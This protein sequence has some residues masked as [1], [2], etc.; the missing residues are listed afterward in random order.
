MVAGGGVPGGRA[1]RGLRT[2]VGNASVAL[3]AGSSW[4][5]LEGGLVSIPRIFH[6]IWVSGDEMPEPVLAARQTWIERHPGWEFRIWRNDDLDWLR[7][8]ALF[9]RAETYAQKADVARY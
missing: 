8:R 6:H 3:R 9:E 5:S 2:R 1:R 4:P 7:N